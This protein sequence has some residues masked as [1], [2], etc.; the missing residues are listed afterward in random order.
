MSAGGR[1]TPSIA[2][3]TPPAPSALRSARW[4]AVGASR[5]GKIGPA[6]HHRATDGVVLGR[7]HVPVGIGD[8]DLMP[9]R[10][11]GI[12]GH[13]PLGVDDGADVAHG[14]VGRGGDLP[15]RVRHRDLPAGE[16]VTSHDLRCT[17]SQPNPWTRARDPGSAE[18]TPV[19][20]AAGRNHAHRAGALQATMCEGE[21]YEPTRVH[22]GRMLSVWLAPGGH[23][24][25]REW[26]RRQSSSV[27][28]G[29]LCFP[30]VRLDGIRSLETTTGWLRW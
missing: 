21:A 17:R 30:M 19:P 14:I 22:G 28:L 6:R 26:H 23:A 29:G 11:V 27:R 10:I 2:N 4:R 7:P 9:H 20:A 18:L 8:L 12:A 24:P 16:R 15:Q 3:R 1:P 25:A 5:R 13:V